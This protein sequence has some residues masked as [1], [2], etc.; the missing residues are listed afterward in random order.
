MPDPS[1]PTRIRPA[2]P[3][4]LDGLVRLCAAHAAYERARYNPEDK[5]ARLGHLLFGPSPRLFGLVAEQGDVLVGYATWS[6]EVS[7]WD[8]QLYAH[9]DCLYLDADAR[10]SGIGRRLV[11]QVARDALGR[12]C[13]LVQWQTP[14]FNTRA[15]PFYD[16]LGAT[17]LEKVRFYLDESAM[18]RLA[19]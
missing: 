17:R 19:G 14:T 5:R 7:T 13:R 9:M 6:E 3:D 16:R 18:K 1:S 10:G 11:S 4:D 8:A 15:L 2:G 12:G